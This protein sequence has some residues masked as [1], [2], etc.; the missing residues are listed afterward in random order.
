MKNNESRNKHHPEA[1]DIVFAKFHGN[2][3]VIRGDH[4]AV[5]L[6]CIGEN[7]LVVPVTDNG[8]TYRK[9]PY[10]VPLEPNDNGLYKPSAAKCESIQCISNGDIRRFAGR[11][12]EEDMAKIAQKL[13][14]TLNLD[15]YLS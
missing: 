2:G 10:H 9:C 3:A 11:C 15:A 7:S 5:V 14:E 1:K 8:R 12:S 4:P 6:R 13:K